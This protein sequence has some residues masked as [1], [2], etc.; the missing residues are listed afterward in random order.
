M[1]SLQS[2][3]LYHRTEAAAS[4]APRRPSHDQAATRR[5]RMEAEPD[6]KIR[7]AGGEL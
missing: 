6:P 5:S 2:V 4:E 1:H 7:R 3:D